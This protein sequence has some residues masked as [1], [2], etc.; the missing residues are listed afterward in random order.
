MPKLA[1][2][3]TRLQHSDNPILSLR[4]PNELTFHLFIIFSL[5]CS[6]YVIDLI[7]KLETRL[8]IVSIFH[9][10]K[11]RQTEISVPRISISMSKTACINPCGYIH[12]FQPEPAHKIHWQQQMH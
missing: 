8:M 5:L 10:I 6:H 2:S 12:Q 4:S 3:P 1:F 7:K 9:K 11:F